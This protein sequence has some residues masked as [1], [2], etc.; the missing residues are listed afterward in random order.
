MGAVKFGITKVPKYGKA[1]AD[2]VKGKLSKTSDTIKSVPIGKNLSTKRAVQDKVVK[3][4]DEG[5]KKGLGGIP[6]SQRLKQSMSKTKRD[7]SKSMKDISYKWDD[8]VS[9]RKAADKKLVK[10]TVGGATA[11]IAGTVGAHEGAKRKWPKYKKVMESDIT[12]KD[13]KLGLKEKK[14]K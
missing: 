13:G 3:A 8:L 7:S 9:K 2:W 5:T 14:K 1:V 12:I 4:V 10:Q 11:A 6:P